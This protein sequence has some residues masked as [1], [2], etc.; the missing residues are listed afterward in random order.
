MQK[1]KVG[2]VLIVV[3]LFMLIY[4]GFNFITTKKVVDLGPIQIDKD[5]NHPVQWSPVLGAVI[6]L[7]G[8]VLT[9]TNRKEKT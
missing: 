4:S 2:I 8:I 6:L 9:A 7:G 1:I 3:G 5:K